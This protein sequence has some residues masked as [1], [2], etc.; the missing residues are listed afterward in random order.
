MA[1]FGLIVFS[2]LDGT[3]LDHHNYSYA[4]ALP[5]LDKLRQTN[6]PLILASSKT[7]SE[8]APLRSELGFAHCAAIVENGAGVLA[9]FDEAIAPSDLY[10]NLVES[11]NELPT[12]FVDLFVG[13]STMSV[14]QIVDETGLSADGA[15]RAKDR[16][17]SEPGLW[18]GNSVQLEEFL[19]RLSERGIAARQGGR[20][21]TL[22]FGGNKAEKAAEI[23]KKTQ[24]VSSKPIISMA[25]GDAPNDI[26]MLQAADF[27]VIIANPA[28][29]ALPILAG[30]DNGQI[31]RSTKPGPEGWS[32]AVLTFISNHID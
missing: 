23:I 14:E 3:L 32:E 8:I 18:Y 6:I 22:S 28:H 17:Y 27:G 31:T 29:A 11:I 30:E 13:F 5:A 10:K 1:D 26:E 25:L 7:P 20:F 9:P 2:D 12:K 4:P 16:H 24:A 21:L 15:R 19:E